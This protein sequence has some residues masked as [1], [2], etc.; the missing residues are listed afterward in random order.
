MGV[1][2]W[3]TTEF[4]RTIDE[5]PKTH[6]LTSASEKMPSADYVTCV[7]TNVRWCIKLVIYDA[8]SMASALMY[9]IELQTQQTESVLEPKNWCIFFAC[10]NHFDRLRTRKNR[11]SALITTIRRWNYMN[12]R[13]VR[14][15]Q[16]RLPRFKTTAFFSR[17]VTFS[18][19]A[20]L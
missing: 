13:F 15:S 7:C 19:S 4:N 18:D 9:F 8:V 6:R 5:Q 16:Q 1:T 11:H 2:N 20:F 10:C 3:I 17:R 14:L 12:T